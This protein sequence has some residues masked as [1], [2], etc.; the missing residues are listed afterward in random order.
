M[1][2]HTISILY[3]DF[4]SLVATIRARRIELGWSQLELDERAGVPSGYTGKLESD[5][6]RKNYRGVGY[7]S[8]PLLLGALGIKMATVVP[9]GRQVQKRGY[10]TD[11]PLEFRALLPFQKNKWMAE[12]GRRGGLRKWQNMTKEQRRAAVA[13]MQKGRAAQRAAR[14][15]ERR[16]KGSDQ[17]S[18][19][20]DTRNGGE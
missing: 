6:A 15:R 1:N 3:D 9:V 13:K 7:V 17:S 2:T 10:G 11:F 14:R 18:T 12:K 8:L 4:R 20:P 5:P 16:E 19:S